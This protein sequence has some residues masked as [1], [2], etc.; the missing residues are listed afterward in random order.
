M[1][2]RSILAA[3]L[4]AMLMSLSV[5]TAAAQQPAHFYP[6]RPKFSNYLLYQQFNATGIPN[7]YTFVQPAERFQRA[8]SQ[9]EAPRQRAQVPLT[10]EQEVAAVLDAQLSQRLTT[11][12]G[13]P[14]V[15]AQF[16]QTSHYYRIPRFAP[17]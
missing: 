10:L 8:L 15:P 12:V 1:C 6:A 5:S 16:N 13:R 9:A 4:A 11:G 7:Y 14:A 2:D 3:V 17:R